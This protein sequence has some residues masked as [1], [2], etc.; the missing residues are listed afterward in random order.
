M[1]VIAMT[2]MNHRVSFLACFPY[3]E[4][5][6]IGLYYHH[7]V[8]VSTLLTFEYLNQSLSELDIHNVAPE[9]ITRT[10]FISPPIGLCV[11]M[12]SPFIVAR[13][14][15]GKDVTAATDTHGT[16][17]EL[18]DASFLCGPCRFNGK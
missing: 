3:F 1:K 7:A 4:K 10:Y 11:C 16:L 2:A 9:P 15:L 8:C 17:E 5:I 12:C 14:R 6:K 18:L 13:Q